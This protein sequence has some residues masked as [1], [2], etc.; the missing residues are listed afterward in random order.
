MIRLDNVSEFDKNCYAKAQELWRQVSSTTTPIS[1]FVTQERARTSPSDKD[2]L[3]KIRTMELLSAHNEAVDANGKYRRRENKYSRS[4]GSPRFQG[5]GTGVDNLQAALE[6]KRPDGTFLPSQ[7]EAAR[8]GRHDV[9][10]DHAKDRLFILNRDSGDFVSRASHLEKVNAH[11]SAARG[12]LISPDALG[13]R[14]KGHA[15][16]AGINALANLLPSADEVVEGV[17]KLAK[18]LD[19]HGAPS[20]SPPPAT[21]HSSTPKPN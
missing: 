13:H 8:L 1:V 14:G 7:L 17:G 19:G 15:V 4:D 12:H 16:V 6:G 9:L 2:Y 20:A 10:N 3:E 5:Q 21:R 11:V 18:A